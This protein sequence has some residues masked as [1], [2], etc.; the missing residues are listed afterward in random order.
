MYLP[1]TS[2]VQS[3][4]L[5]AESIRDR[6]SRGV[7]SCQSRQHSGAVLLKR[8]LPQVIGLQGKSRK[9]GEKAW[10]EEQHCKQKPGRWAEQSA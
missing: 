8:Y 5:L 1:Q 2:L 7:L 10:E 3:M 6:L 4:S 9:M